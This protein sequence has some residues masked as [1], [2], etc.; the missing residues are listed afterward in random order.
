MGAAADMERS[1]AE[2][3]AE[4]QR[5]DALVAVAREECTGAWQWPLAPM[6]KNQEMEV[7]TSGCL[8]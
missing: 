2:T 6:M 1:E 8:G 3:E 5:A 4:P 7:E